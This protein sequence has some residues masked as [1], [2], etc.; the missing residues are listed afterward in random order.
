LRIRYGIA[1][2]GATI[3][4]GVGFLI[5]MK[6]YD[7]III[8]SGAGLEVL[9]IAV[10]H[11][12]KTALI[13]DSPPGGTCLNVGCLPSKMLIFPADRILEIKESAA[14]GI[15]AEIKRIDFTAIM[16]RMR[17][18]VGSDRRSV[19]KNLRESKALDFYQETAEFV[20]PYTLKVGGETVK[21]K[22]IYLASGSRPF[23]PQVD[24]I[25][26]VEYLTS[27][28]LLHLKEP[29]ESLI[30]VGGGYIGVEY[31]HFFEAMGSK[32]TL[33]ELGDRLLPEE[34]PEIS[35]LLQKAMIR[36]MEVLTSQKALSVANVAGRVQVNVKHPKTGR[37]RS[38]EA[39]TILLATG[40]V[41]NADRLKVEKGGIKLD[42]RGYI[43]VDSHLETNIKGIYAIGDANGREMFT[44]TSRAEASVAAAN[45]IHGKKETMDYWSAPHAIFSHPQIASVGLTEE[46]AVRKKYKVVVGRADYAETAL[47]TAMGVKEGFAKII[48]EEGTG[49]FL[50]GH[51]I[52]PWASA[53]IQEV[54]NAMAQKGGFFDIA[55]GIHIHP[56]LPE[57]IVKALDHAA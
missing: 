26:K 24:G 43:K 44:H 34:E 51:I 56:A 3:A 10:E 23:I 15:E 32:V 53:L 31:A 57:I 29:P 47:G 50:G 12:L 1:D 9:D 48:M 25:D 52:G 18:V 42:R 41:S 11:G 45:G 4:L 36:R 40:R 27:E 20:E 30:V 13:D 8:G 14:L 54:V 17:R 28:S 22:Q 7:V 35:A 39:R 21:A 6:E 49:K 46:A 16:A 33:I 2:S 37:S 19:E 38:L 55:R 5:Y